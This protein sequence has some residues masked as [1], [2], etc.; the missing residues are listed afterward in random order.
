ME[1]LSFTTARIKVSSVMILD[2][3]ADIGSFFL[4]SMLCYSLFYIFSFHG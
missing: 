4:Q 1:L 2:N 3:P